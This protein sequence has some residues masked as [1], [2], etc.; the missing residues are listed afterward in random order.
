MKPYGNVGFT[1]II[2]A[3]TLPTEA[4]CPNPSDGDGVAGMIRSDSVGAWAESYRASRAAEKG[5]GPE[6]N[7]D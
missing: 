4:S 6:G 5:E 1:I 3:F 7:S 2:I